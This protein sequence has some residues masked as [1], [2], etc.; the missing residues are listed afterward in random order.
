MNCI[1]L[2]NKNLMN[3]SNPAR[4]QHT[5]PEVYLKEFTFDSK[6]KKVYYFDKSWVYNKKIQPKS[7]SQL[8]NRDVFTR[9]ETPEADV[10]VE[11]NKMRILDDLYGKSLENV[12]RSVN[13]LS[14]PSELDLVNLI[15]FLT[16]LPVRTLEFAEKAKDMSTKII[17]NKESLMKTAGE[18]FMKTFDK[19]IY[20]MT[21]Q[22]KLDFQTDAYLSLLNDSRSSHYALNIM[23][24]QA[25]KWQEEIFQRSLH[26]V[27]LRTGI[28]LTSDNPF[29]LKWDVSAKDYGD[30]PIPIVLTPQIGI[31]I[32]KRKPD[33]DNLPIKIIEITEFEQAFEDFNNAVIENSY[34]RIYSQ[35][36]SVFEKYLKTHS[37]L[38]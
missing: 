16:Y 29:Y 9:F 22:D 30:K 26:F 28:F 15:S 20:K 5:I 13:S 6:R 31:V 1:K 24:R 12:K 18:T 3:K 7:I 34:L 33:R 19:D 4:N 14:I 35:E 27:N 38:D 21:V 23:D 25:K 17:E 8:Y 37:L 36:T 11:I 2:Y 10:S 32:G